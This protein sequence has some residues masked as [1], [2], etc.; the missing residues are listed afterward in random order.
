MKIFALVASAFAFQDPCLWNLQESGATTRDRMTG[1]AGES[2]YILIDGNES[3]IQACL[4]RDVMTT[5]PTPGCLR[6]FLK[7]KTDSISFGLSRFWLAN[8]I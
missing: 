3:W 2:D 6:E 1:Y 7:G 4:E 8:V 5:A